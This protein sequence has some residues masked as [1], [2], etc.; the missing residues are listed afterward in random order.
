MNAWLIFYLL[1]QKRS[2]E[3]MEEMADGDLTGL[4]VT[5]FAICIVIILLD[6]ALMWPTIVRWLS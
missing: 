6:I 2:D 3:V 1:N 4:A 5:W